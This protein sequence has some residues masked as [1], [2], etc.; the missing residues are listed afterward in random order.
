MRIDLNK[1]L[2]ADEPE[3][4]ADGIFVPSKEWQTIPD[5]AAMPNGGEYRMNQA[6]GINQARWDDP[7][8]PETVFD[9]RTGKHQAVFPDEPGKEKRTDAQTSAQNQTQQQNS[10]TYRSRVKS[11]LIELTEEECASM[12]FLECE[13][14]FLKHNGLMHQWK[15]PTVDEVHPKNRERTKIFI[16][17]LFKPQPSGCGLPEWEDW[18]DYRVRNIPMPN[19]IIDGILHQGEIIMIGGATKT[20]KSWTMPEMAHAVATGSNFLGERCNKGTVYY[21][22]SELN[23]YFFQFRNKKIEESR[24]IFPERGFLNIMRLRGLESDVFGLSKRIIADLKGKSPSLIVIDPIYLLLGEDRQ[25]NSND[26]IKSFGK[27]LIKITRETGAA[28]AFVHHFSK[29]RKDDQRGIERVSGAGSWGRIPDNSMS[30]NKPEKSDVFQ[31]E[32]DLRNFPGRPII[33]AERNGYIWK[34]RRDLEGA[35]RQ[36]CL[37][38]NVTP[39]RVCKYV[40]GVDPVHQDRVLI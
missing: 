38:N 16:D 21:V 17:L 33:I 19:V 2:F 40:T 14:L 20:F 36:S 34:R 29:G 11:S 32:F 5:W 25:E 7:P 15:P 27:E 26:D 13:R 22:D 3:Q 30:I 23:E 6:S 8:G 12:A 35:E 4:S 24:N 28:L 18:A 9:K 1:P 10:N 31:F 37:D 39:E